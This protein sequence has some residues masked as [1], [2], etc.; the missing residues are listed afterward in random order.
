LGYIKNNTPFFSNAV[1]VNIVAK[2]AFTLDFGFFDP[3]SM[4]GLD[5]STSS[6][7]EVDAVSRIVFTREVAESLLKQLESALN[8]SAN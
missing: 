3:L 4:K 7:H 8:T 1:L 6:S 2:D 5:V